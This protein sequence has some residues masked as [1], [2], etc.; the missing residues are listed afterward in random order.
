MLGFGTVYKIHDR[1]AFRAKHAIEEFVAAGAEFDH[2]VLG[3]MVANPRHQSFDAIF[4]ATNFGLSFFPYLFC[5]ALQAFPSPQT[6]FIDWEIV[7]SH[8]APSF[9]P[10][11]VELHNLCAPGAVVFWH[12]WHLAATKASAAR[13]HKMNCGGSRRIS[14]YRSGRSGAGRAL[15]ERVAQWWTVMLACL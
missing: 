6:H 2:D 10:S 15:T 7:G 13:R 3:E 5:I 4:V 14:D 9:N 1:F 8:A 11:V 12:S